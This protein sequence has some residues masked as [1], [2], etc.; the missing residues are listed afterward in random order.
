[1][2]AGDGLQRGSGVV[3]VL[4]WYFKPNAASQPS[5]TALNHYSIET[6]NA[7][8]K[9]S[10]NFVEKISRHENILKLWS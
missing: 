4:S 3:V 10:A 5:E 1:M 6:A 2:W 8:I 9:N 7:R